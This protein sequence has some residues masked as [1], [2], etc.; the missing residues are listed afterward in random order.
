MQDL[1]RSRRGLRWTPE[2]DGRLIQLALEN[3]APGA[4]AKDLGRSELSCARAQRLDVSFKRPAKLKGR[5][6]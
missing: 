3:R 1:S 5:T 4:I 2:H 6:R